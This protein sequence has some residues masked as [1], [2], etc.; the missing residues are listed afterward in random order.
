MDRSDVV[1]LL[2]YE[3]IQNEYGVRVKSEEPIARQ[4]YC[5][6]DSVT[7]SEYFNGGVNGIRPQYRITMFRYDYN[8][9]DIVEYNGELLTVYRTYFATNDDI[10][11]YVERRTGDR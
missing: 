5:H 1:N 10:E 7:G 2:S 11:L 6:V 4:V 3:F 9:E 8:G